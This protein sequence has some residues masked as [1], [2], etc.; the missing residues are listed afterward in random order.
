MTNKS[1]RA[2]AMLRSPVDPAILRLLR[3]L[4]PIAAQLKSP[5]FVAGATARDLILVNLHGLPPGRATYDV[6]FGV[7]VRDWTQ[8]SYLKEQLIA[9]GTFSSTATPHRL[10]YN[11]SIGGASIPVDLI[12][13]GGIESGSGF[14]AWP[15]GHDVLLNVAGFD[16]AFASSIKLEFEPGLIIPVAS[17]PGLA[18]LKLTAWMD[19]GRETNK[20]AADLRQLLI[21]YGD[22]GN[23]DRL[24][25]R[26]LDLLEA[27]NFDIVLAGAELLGC[28]VTAICGPKCLLA[29][30]SFLTLEHER[31]RLA[32]GMVRRGHPEDDSLLQRIVTAFS[33]GIHIAGL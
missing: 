26:E 6:D 29:V 5:Y 24:F 16:E 13:F 20:D 33:R 12:P 7:S 23:T 8:F 4:D 14:I 3:V 10:L 19:R 17:T 2:L 18:L 22:A 9:T 30:R 21:S 25:D 11:D 28:D 15:P 27:A 1:Y 32:A 31:E